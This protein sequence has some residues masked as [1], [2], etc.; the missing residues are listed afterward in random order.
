MQLKR[1]KNEQR[2]R[3]RHTDRHR[4]RG[5]YFSGTKQKNRR[6]ETL[7]AE[8]VDV[9][10]VVLNI[11]LSACLVRHRK[12]PRVLS[13]RPTPLFLVILTAYMKHGFGQA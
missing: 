4:E 1:R 10:V 7:E 5:R 13:S 6:R 3:L 8:D 9:V 11:V 12:Q 2:K